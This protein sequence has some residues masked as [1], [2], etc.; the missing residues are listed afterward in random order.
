MNW[1]HLVG[2]LLVAFV[3]I[4]LSNHVSAIKNITG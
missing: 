4:W 2:S 3:A 1:K